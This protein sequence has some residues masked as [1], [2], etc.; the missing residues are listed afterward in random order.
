MITS[1]IIYKTKQGTQKKKKTGFTRDERAQTFY[2][3]VLNQTLNI[4]ERDTMNRFNQYYLHVPH[5]VTL[6]NF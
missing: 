3:E 5:Y 4:C 1:C 2:K 6:D